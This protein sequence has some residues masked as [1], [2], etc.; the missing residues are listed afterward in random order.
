MLELYN[1]YSDESD[2]II[3]SADG[4]LTSNIH[5]VI[6]ANKDIL[7]SADPNKFAAKLSFKGVIQKEDA[8][9]VSLASTPSDKATI[10]VTAI[11]HQISREISRLPKYTPQGYT[12]T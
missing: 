9:Q 8:I 6:I 12:T 7:T 4:I 11:E 5:K 2:P 10:L 3:I 1:N